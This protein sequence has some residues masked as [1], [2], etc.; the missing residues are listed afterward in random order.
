MMF[1]SPDDPPISSIPSTSAEATQA[2]G[3]GDLCRYFY[4]ALKEDFE[5]YAAH[6]VTEEGFSV[7][8]LI[9]NVVACHAHD[10]VLEEKQVPLLRPGGDVPDQHAA[11]PGQGAPGQGAWVHPWRE[12][13]VHCWLI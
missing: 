5:D 11:Q 3:F 7:T 8:D 1:P 2:L 9:S 6:N 12:F 4:R 10:R 13:P